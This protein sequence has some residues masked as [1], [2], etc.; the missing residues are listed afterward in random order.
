MISNYYDL[1]E[2]FT[3]GLVRNP[4]DWEVSKYFYMKQTSKHFQYNL[5]NSFNSFTEYLEWRATDYK[6]QI[7]FFRDANGEI[8]VDYICK[9]EEIYKLE[10]KLKK[11]FD[12]NVTFPRINMSKREEHKKY[13]SKKD[14]ELVNEIHG[15]DIKEFNY[16]F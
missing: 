8:K 1:D 9:V 11:E 10:E 7:D 12:I 2:Y 6:N 3:F 16:T 15:I 4:W 13:F 14:I 5:A